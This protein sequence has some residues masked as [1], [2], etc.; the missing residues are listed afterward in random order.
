MDEI[1]RRRLIPRRGFVP[2]RLLVS[3]AV[4]LK[5]PRFS[6]GQGEVIGKPRLSQAVDLGA[7]YRERSKVIHRCA[8]QNSRRCTNASKWR[9]RTRTGKRHVAVGQSPRTSHSRRT[10]DHSCQ[11]PALTKMRGLKIAGGRR[12]RYIGTSAIRSGN[13][14]AS[15]SRLGAIKP[16]SVMRPVTSRAGVTSKA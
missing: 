1:F 2:V 6:I 5:A 13:A 10:C 16:R 12:L 14:L 11:Q 15:A 7:F 3:H 9:R 4:K 8:D